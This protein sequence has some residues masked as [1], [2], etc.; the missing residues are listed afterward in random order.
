MSLASVRGAVVTG[1]QG[2]SGLRVYDHIPD[3]FNQ[4]PAVAVRLLAANYT[5]STYRFR[6]LLV[7]AGWDVAEAELA[8]H[9][10]LEKAGASSIRQVLNAD[11][12]CLCISAG[13]VERKLLN[14]LP[15]MGVDLTVVAKDV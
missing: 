8:L 5:D 15:Y 1:L 6:L 13:P 3:A 7:T 9:P 2:I 10:Y 4:F 14:G 11:P 12:N